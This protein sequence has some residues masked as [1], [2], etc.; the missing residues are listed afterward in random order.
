MKLAPFSDTHPLNKPLRLLLALALALVLALAHF[1]VI[2]A[3]ASRAASQ[4]QS[5]YYV[6]ETT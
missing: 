5:K 1:F 6:E 3:S 4:F 2:V